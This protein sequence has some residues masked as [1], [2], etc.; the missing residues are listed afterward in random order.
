MTIRD[1][2]AIRFP[3]LHSI[4][5]NAAGLIGAEWFETGI[6]A[7]YALLIARILG[8]G[9]YGVWS[10]VLA[11][12]GFTISLSPLGSEIL[13]PAR[14]GRDGKRAGS[15]LDT[16][17]AVRLGL[18]A[19]LGAGLVAYAFITE[20]AGDVR[21]ALIILVLSVMAR[22]STMLARLFAVG[23]ERTILMVRVA[24]LMRLAEI[25]CGAALLLSGAGILALVALHATMWIVEA[26]WAL[27]LVRRHLYPVWPRIDWTELGDYLRQGTIIGIAGS[28][29][30]AIV[31]VS[32][33]SLKLVSG[34]LEAV[35]QFGLAVQLSMFAAMAILGVQSA[36]LAV[37]S[38]AHAVQ[39]WRAGLYGAA[40]MALCLAL[41]PPAW[42]AARWLGVPLLTFLLGQ[43]YSAAG[44]LLAPCAV[45]AITANMSNG[46]WQ[47]LVLQRRSWVGLIAGIAALATMVA[48]APWAIATY[49][50]AGAAWAG[51]FAALV[52]GAV[53][54]AGTLKVRTRRKSVP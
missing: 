9:G 13:V 47:L 24:V 11:V 50:T 32:L 8:P 15:F 43:K 19:I 54:I 46:F 41:L 22:G 37:L 53:L 49:G 40:M 39:D 23:F 51:V 30:A 31:S 25:C 36:S 1:R 2:L 28:L 48:S 20:A 27:S 12:T 16:V 6:R 33:I 4:A 18:L 29:Q 26:V 44:D 34:D 38:R 35:G 5:R 17:F 45:M 42:F 52:R 14:I 3:G 10:Y 21:W 7:V